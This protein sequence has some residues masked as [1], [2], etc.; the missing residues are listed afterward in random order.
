MLR[1]LPPPV[2]EAIEVLW[3]LLVAGEVVEVGRVGRS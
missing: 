3:V 2:V 1:L